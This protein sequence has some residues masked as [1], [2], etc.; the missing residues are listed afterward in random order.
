[1][2][3]GKTHTEIAGIKIET[4]N[5]WIIVIQKANRLPLKDDGK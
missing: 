5:K 4:Q 3:N 1:M 2:L